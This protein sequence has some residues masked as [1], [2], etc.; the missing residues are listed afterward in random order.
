MI[1]TIRASRLAIISDLHLGNPFN[2]RRGEIIAFLHWA[3]EAG[4]DIVINGDGLE[5]AQASLASVAR[6]VPEF[7]HALRRLSTEGRTV[8]Y[9]VGN[10]D[11]ALENFLE[12]WGSLRVAP[13]LNI[14]SGGKRIRVEHG[15]LYDPFFVK[16]PRLYEAATWLGGVLLKIYP[17]LY[18]AWIGLERWRSYWRLKTRGIVGEPPEFAEAAR[19]IARRGFDFVIFG[20]THHSGQ[21]QLDDGASYL[22]PGSWLLAS[23]FVEISEGEVSLRAW[24][25]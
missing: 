15:H 20:H 1:T 8:Y 17:P 14:E 23:N 9:V 11:I 7:V 10:H 21:I 12:D 4:Y 5:I 13:F 2:R 6:D 19:E 25:R 24:E 22:N 3:A 16:S 18:R